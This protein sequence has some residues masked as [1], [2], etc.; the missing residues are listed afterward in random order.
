MGVFVCVSGTLFTYYF[1]LSLSLSLSFFLI[2]FISSSKHNLKS[3]YFGAFLNVYEYDDNQ[4]FSRICQF[5][6]F[7]HTKRKVIKKFEL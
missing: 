4:S 1:S 6:N 5:V 3:D 7:H 2:I